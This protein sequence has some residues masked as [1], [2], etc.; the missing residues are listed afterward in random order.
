MGLISYASVFK[1]EINMAKGAYI[2]V[3][4]VARNITQPYIGTGGVS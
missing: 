2:G 3:S 4:G 1:G